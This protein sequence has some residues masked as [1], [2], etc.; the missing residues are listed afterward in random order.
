MANPKWHVAPIIRQMEDARISVGLLIPLASVGYT[1]Q[2]G[3]ETNTY[4]TNTGVAPPPSNWPLGS[5]TY[6][7]FGGSRQVPTP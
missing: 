6:F 1:V 7:Y 3:E 4:A 2:V 5:N